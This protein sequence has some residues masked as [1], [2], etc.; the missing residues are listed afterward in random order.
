M[1]SMSVTMMHRD[2]LCM[3]KSMISFESR[4]LYYVSSSMFTCGSLGKAKEWKW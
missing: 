3:C 4:M 1:Y 2:P